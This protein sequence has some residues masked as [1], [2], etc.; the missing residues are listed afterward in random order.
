MNNSDSAMQSTPERS[1]INDRQRIDLFDEIARLNNELVTAHREL[2][3]RNAELH[4]A[5]RRKDQ[6]L[7]IAVHDMRTPLNLITVCGEALLE[8]DMLLPQ[9]REL[10][11]TIL[12]SARFM[13]T[14]VN[15]LLD[16]T[17][18]ESG[19]LS[20]NR[21]QTDLVGLMRGSVQRNRLLA[22]TKDV[23]IHYLPAGDSLL[24]DVDPQRIEQVLNN[25]LANALKYSPRG[26]RIELGLRWDAEAAVIAVADQGPG[27]DSQMAETLFEPFQHHTANHAN[28]TSEKSTGLGLT[29][30][31]NIIEAHRGAVWVESTPG[32]GATFYCRLPLE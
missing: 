15:D 1:D 4:Q 17:V 5:N 12:S 16:I 22:D 29:I 25:L 28:A 32:N 20:L 30:V 10:L 31:R 21:T 6:N 18:I 14:L 7:G 2:A 8:G 27:I 26:S 19:N 13:A 23:V 24:V 11:A 9:Q 3:R